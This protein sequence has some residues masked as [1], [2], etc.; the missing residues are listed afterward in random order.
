MKYKVG[1]RVRIESLSVLQ[2]YSEQNF[3]YFCTVEPMFVYANKIAKIEKY[4]TEEHDY[5]YSIDIDGG[6]FYWRDEFFAG[7]ANPQLELFQ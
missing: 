5:Q 2:K 4:L 1:D 6:N 3:V 7:R